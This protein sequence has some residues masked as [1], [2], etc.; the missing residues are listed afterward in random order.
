VNLLSFFEESNVGDG[1]RQLILSD[2]ERH[3]LISFLTQRLP[4][5]YVQEGWV[6]ER[7]ATTGRTARELLQNK[8][9]DQGAVMSGDFGEILTMHVLDSSCVEEVELVNKWRH[10]Q[11]RLKAA[12]HSDVVLLHRVDPDKPSEE[13]FVISA[14][15]KAKATKKKSYSPISNALDGVEKDRVGRLARTLAWLYEKALDSGSPQEIKSF[16][17]FRDPVSTTFG[18]KYH[19]VVIV[20]RDFIETELKASSKIEIDPSIEV[21]VIG[22][23]DLKSCYEEVFDRA[24]SDEA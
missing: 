4:L 16:D 21:L 13:D 19:A 14:E 22:I 8:F 3:S 20:E 5:C 15:A 17:R 6:E 2:G 10:K 12:P 7:V 24:L 9:P 1:F 11:D 18:K 23:T